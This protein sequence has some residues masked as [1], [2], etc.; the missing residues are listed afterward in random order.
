MREANSLFPSFVLSFIFLLSYS[1]SFQILAFVIPGKVA[2]PVSFIGQDLDA[3]CFCFT[4]R[5]SIL[6]GK[7]S[8]NIFSSFLRNNNNK[9]AMHIVYSQNLP[10]ED[11][12]KQCTYHGAEADSIV[13]ALDQCNSALNNWTTECT[14]MFFMFIIR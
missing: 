14:G 2:R 10:K 6:Q 9:K 8:N 11:L 5:E 7:V 1:C 13:K 3:K 12:K 4:L